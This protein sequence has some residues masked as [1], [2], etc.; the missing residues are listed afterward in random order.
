MKNITTILLCLLSFTPFAQESWV[1]VV[2]QTDDYGAETSW[3]I[4]QDTLIVAV[5][6]VYSNNSY[7]ETLVNLPVGGY[8]FVIY[9][10]FGDGI[11]CDFG[12][13]YFGLNNTCGL[14]TFMYDFNGP[15]ATVYFDLLACPPPI[16][17]CMEVEA[18][19]F[20]PW[21]TAPA[22]CT[23]P[24]APCDT[25][26]TNI[27]VL[28]TSDS[29]PSE[30]SWDLTA[31]G[32]IVAQ[33]G[34]YTAIGV[35]TPTYVCVQVGDTIVASVYDA[36]GDGLCGS[37][38][39]GVDGYFDVTTLCD[40]SVFFAG[41]ETQFDTL[42]SGPYVV[43]A[44]FAIE[45]QGCTIP[46]YV[47][48]NSAAVIDDGSC[49]TPI[50]LG[51]TDITMFN[52]DL[53][54]N[55]MDVHPSCTYTLTTT[56]GGADGWFGSWLGLTQGDNIYGPFEMGPEDGY[57]EAFELDLNSNE[58][59][60][61]YF[62]SPGNAATTAAQCGFRLEGPNGLV[63]QS[64][65]NPWT[66][67]LKKFPFTYE[68]TPICLNYCEEYVNGCMDNTAVNYDEAANT[69]EGC[70]YTPGCMNGGYM[71]FF[72]QGY[73]ADFDDGSCLT[74]VVFGCL[75]PEFFNYN[76]EANV[77]NEG[78]LP[79]IYGCMNPLASNYDP[80]ANSD[81]DCVPY[82]YGCTDAQMFNYNGEAT[83]EDGSCIPYVYGCTDPDSFNYNIDANTDNDSCVD[84]VEGCMDQSAENYQ[85]LA[86]INE[87]TE[88]LYDAGC[89]GGPGEPYYA[90]DEC[91]SWVIE[92]DPYCCNVSWDDT[93]IE[94]YEYCG[95]EPT[96]VAFLDLTFRIYPN[97]TNNVI[98]I[99][100][101]FKVVTT[102]YDILGKR[103]IAPTND[104]AIELSMLSNGLYEVRVEYKGRIVS[105]KIIKQ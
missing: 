65:T 4:Y 71:E 70:Y 25:G 12:E 62:F 87:I 59:V 99:V 9:D 73:D 2:V 92:V 85:A 31:N 36:Y 100:S 34:G 29:Y 45:L 97:P 20:N 60:K 23:F 35:T 64:G 78:C 50:Q 90:N 69:D 44:C 67:L 40:D 8:N 48:Y 82:V 38:W 6:P 81:A 83:T 46:G 17:G 26:A 27:I 24:P 10:Q 21:A 103:V 47:E 28:V 42:A 94:L 19:N 14:N 75:D 68:G 30:T 52:Y 56:D 76:P 77:D 91:Y 41:G 16:F 105:N 102:V 13:G 84:M 18:I 88:C 15:T 7:N 101:P 33:G 58:E 93:C 96:G 5:S 32:E 80:L 57:E 63:L 66:D 49:I 22:P 53:L 79:Y 54:A 39:G 51:C 95:G 89:Y 98:N 1:N 86:N 104:T 43:P 11:C 72:T 37:C 61:V 74:P 55:T 3:E